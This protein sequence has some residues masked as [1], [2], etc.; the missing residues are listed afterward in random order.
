[1]SLPFFLQGLG[2]V[3]IFASRAFLPAFATALML[4]LGPDVPWLGQVGLL[5]HVRDVPTW[6]TSNTALIVLGVL[7]AL[8]LLAERSPE[9]KVVFDELHDY[10]KAGM[11]ALTYLGVL[12]TADRA[13]VGP[14]INHAGNGDYAPMLGVAVGTLAL[15][16]ARSVVV[17]PLADAD[18]DDDL[19]LQRLLRWAGDLWGG[20]GAVVLVVLPLL[21]LAA[22]GVA[23]VVLVVIERRVSARLAHLM[24]ACATCARPIHPS[25]RAC[26]HCRAAVAEP[27]AVSFLGLPKE[28]PADPRSL[29][30]D[31]VAAKRC[32]ICAT[33]FGRR[34]VV[35]ACGVCGD[36]SLLDPDFARDYVAAIDRRVPLACAVGFGLGLVP[37]LGVI[38][39]VIYYRLAI[40]APFRRYIPPT[41]GLLLRWGVRVAVVLLVATQWVPVAGGLALPAM[42]MISY[43][44][45]RTAYRGLAADQAGVAR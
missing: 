21:A 36:E 10:L 31:L 3:G 30:F 2:S 39:G 25:A 24:A 26:P 23:A 41:R 17:G 45:Y 28:A 22:F 13:A 34:A 35:Q 7:A 29:P 42:G 27:R 32:P 12:G 16:R 6:F 19:G 37:V 18:E 5:S 33:R 8:E 40:V 9:A 15:A 44:A 38:P 1:M 43:L 20:L 14:L 4:R 11:A